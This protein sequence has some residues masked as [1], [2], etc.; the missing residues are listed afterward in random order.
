MVQHHIDIPNDDDQSEEALQSAYLPLGVGSDHGRPVVPD[1]IDN[2][3]TIM[4][5][6]PDHGQPVTDQHA[7]TFTPTAICTV[8]MKFEGARISTWHAFFLVSEAGAGFDNHLKFAEARLADMRNGS[9]DSV[10]PSREGRNFADFKFGG[11]Q[12]IFM[13]I[14]NSIDVVFDEINNVRFTKFAADRDAHGNRRLMRKNACFRNGQFVDGRGSLRGA[15]ILYLENW[16]QKFRDEA[17]ES[18]HQDISN[19]PGQST[20]SEYLE[21]SMNIHLLM[22]SLNGNVDIPIIIDPTTGNGGGAQ[23]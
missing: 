18:G 1:A 22:K 5:T 15:R 14:D 9:W 8:Y 10:R 2:R 23:P 19:S 13:F 12:R 20:H 7:A 16:F 6:N 11:R 17:N 4:G 21:Y 3:N